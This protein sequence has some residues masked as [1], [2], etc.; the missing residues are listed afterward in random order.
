[1]GK[2][3]GL[4][5]EYDGNE[6]VLGC[7]LSDCSL[8]FRPIGSDAML[9]EIAIVRDE[10]GSFFQGVLMPLAARF[11]GDL[12]VRVIWNESEKN[13]QGNWAE[14]KV[15][16]GA[17]EDGPPAYAPPPVSSGPGGEQVE[18]PEPPDPE[19]ALSPEESEIRDLLEKAREH[20]N[21]Y[22]RLKGAK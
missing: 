17:A 12:H 13:T 21:E 5:L 18:P 7:T 6:L 2:Q 16:R 19:A 3:L 10:A 1:L 11:R 14:V 8:R 15:S 4:A 22:Q 20:W 9:S